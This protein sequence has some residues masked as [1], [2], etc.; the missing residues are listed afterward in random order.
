MALYCNA[1]GFPEPTVTWAKDGVDNPV[2]R[3]PWLN[4]TNINRRKSGSYTC[5]ANNT[6]EKHSSSERRINVL[7]KNTFF[8]H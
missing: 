2:A 7:C 1:T 3:T 6:C 4:F 8:K 5:H